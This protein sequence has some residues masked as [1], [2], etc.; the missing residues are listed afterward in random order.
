LVEAFTAEFFAA[1][2]FAVEV[3]AFVTEWLAR[4]RVNESMLLVAGATVVSLR[5]AVLT[6]MDSTAMEPALKVMRR[7]PNC[8]SL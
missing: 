2:V 8:E 3:L 1:G 6:A 4:L 5:A 7:N